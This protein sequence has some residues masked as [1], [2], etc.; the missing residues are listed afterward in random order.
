MKELAFFDTN[1]F[2]YTDDDAAPHKQEVAIQLIA[3]YQEKNLAMISLQVMQEYFALTTRKLGVK[4]EL[5]QKKVEL[6]T[7]MRVVRFSEEDVVR[8]IELHRLH[9]ISFWDAMIVHA[10]RIGGAEILYT[11]D[12]QHGGRFGELRVINPFA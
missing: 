4:A 10:A 8:A 5:A 6:M 3:R 2:V 12:L 9:R 1:V 7:R 11:E